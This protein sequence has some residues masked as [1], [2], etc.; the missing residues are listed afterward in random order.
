[1]NSLSSIA[2]DTELGRS[3][4]ESAT[5]TKRN[6]HGTTKSRLLK[7][8]ARS[9]ALVTVSPLFL[10]HAIGSVASS[11]DASLESHSQILSLV[12]GKIGSYLRVAFYRR[13]LQHCASSATIGFGVLLSKTGARIHDNTYIGP[14]CMLGLVTLEKDVLLGPAVQIPSGGATHGFEKSDTPIRLQKGCQSRITIGPDCWIGAGSVVLTNVRAHSVVG[15]GSVVTKE[16]S[17]NSILA[18][19]PARFVR[20]RQAT[21]PPCSAKEQNDRR[22][23]R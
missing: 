12:P 8:I 5:P 22:D 10:S 19:N 9:I 15:A 6:H 14:R 16:H 20:E 21:A 3:V 17:E 7:P 13:T 2:T 4:A 11:A 23:Q 18:G 1:M